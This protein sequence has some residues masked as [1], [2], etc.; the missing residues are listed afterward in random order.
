MRESKQAIK[1][2]RGIALGHLGWIS[3]SFL[4]FSIPL[5]AI[6]KDTYPAA[7]ILI[8]LSVIGGAIA[9]GILLWCKGGPIPQPDPASESELAELA[10]LRKT[11]SS[12]EQRLESLETINSYEHKLAERN[13]AERIVMDEPDNH[14]SA[15]R[16]T[17]T[18][19]S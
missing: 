7:S 8:P 15:A 17:D 18:T 16:P 5:V 6:L 13:W 4:V 12:L 11:I 3:T 19:A 14:A 10:E 9:C 1:D 2:K